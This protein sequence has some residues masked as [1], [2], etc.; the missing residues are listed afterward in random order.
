[1]CK[2]KHKAI[3]ILIGI[4]FTGCVTQPK[5]TTEE[6]KI[7]APKIVN[8]N[9]SKAYRKFNKMMKLTPFKNLTVQV[10]TVKNATT[11]KLQYD[12]K[13]FIERPLIEFIDHMNVMAYDPEYQQNETATTGFRSRTKWA[14]YVIVGEISQFDNGGYSEGSD[15]DLDGEFGGGKGLT[16]ATIG[17]SDGFSKSSITV[18]LKVKN[19]NG[20]YL[21]A[22]SN[23]I[24][25]HQKNKSNSI[26]IFLN[27]I[28]LGVSKNA[29]MKHSTDQALRLVSEYGLLQLLGRFYNLPYWKCFEPSMPED[30]KVINAWNTEFNIALKENKT[31]ILLES[32]LLKGYGL[33]F[34]KVNNK[35]DKNELNILKQIRKNSNIVFNDIYSSDF[36]I[37]LYKNIPLFNKQ[38]V[39]DIESGFS[40]EF[41]LVSKSKK[42]NIP[43]KIPTNIVIQHSTQSHR[44]EENNKVDTNEIQLYQEVF[45]N[46]KNKKIKRYRNEGSNNLILID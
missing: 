25:L 44:T 31:N 10:A 26:G 28:G 11:G 24:E 45:S 43:E 27:N 46:K 8:S 12:I 14:D 2:I 32:V 20:I 29:S 6:Q 42:Q 13:H 34:V 41:E 9:Y 19:N 1:M 22:V 37:E 23:S 7:K 40:N 33:D 16:T 39:L 4:I 35:L 5:F 17:S 3:I 30:Y 21:T 38:K 36:Y 15:I 18:D